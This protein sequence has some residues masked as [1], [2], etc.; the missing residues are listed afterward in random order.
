MRGTK[1][2]AWQTPPIWKTLESGDF[3]APENSTVSAEQKQLMK[4][5]LKTLEAVFEDVR[6]GLLETV[7]VDCVL[8]IEEKCSFVLDLP[9]G[10]DTEQIAKAIDMEN[11]E[12]WR[13]ETGAVHVALSPWFS[14]KDVD[15]SVLSPVKAIH[16][17][18]GIHATDNAPPPTFGQKILSTVA[19]IM[20]I[21]KKIEKR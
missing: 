11:V 4:A 7:G 9:E 5:I 3:A 12:A 17:L 20:N 15:Q 13:D 6:G 10:T 1:L 14:T 18:I 8:S 19:D 2:T 16:V 21:Q